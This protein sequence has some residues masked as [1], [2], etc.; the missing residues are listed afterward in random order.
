MFNVYCLFNVEKRK[1]APESSTWA[2]SNFLREIN[3]SKETMPA[4]KS[5]QGESESLIL[6]VRISSE[7][8]FFLFC[9]VIDSDIVSVLCNI[10]P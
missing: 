7:S 2:L 9:V 1:D 10:F 5:G 6:H 8:W 3:Q 4:G